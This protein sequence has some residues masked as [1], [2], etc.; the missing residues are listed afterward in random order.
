MR[1]S[2]LPVWG[3]YLHEGCTESCSRYKQRNLASKERLQGMSVE[4]YGGYF[5]SSL[6][7]Q[8]WDVSRVMGQPVLLHLQ[9]TSRFVAKGA[10][11]TKS[12]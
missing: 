6:G 4:K 11:M 12:L 1:L 10:V 2:E 8:I 9:N 3:R 7:T 5:L